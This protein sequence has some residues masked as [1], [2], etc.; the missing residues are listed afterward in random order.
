LIHYFPFSGNSSDEVTGQAY[1]SH[2]ATY[3]SD[4]KG[5]EASAI[6]FNGING[7]MELGADLQIPEGTLALWIFP[8][9]CKEYNPLFVKKSVETDGQFGQYYV[10]YS[11]AGRIETSCNGKWNLETGVAIEANKWFH[12]AFRWN[13]ATG[14]IDVFVNGKKVLSEQYSTDPSKFPGGAGETFLGKILNKSASGEEVET[15]YY[16]GKLDEIRLY[17][18]ALPYDAIKELYTE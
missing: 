11:E 9:L 3:L 2:G 17:D 4:R 1:D 16:K 8:C 12:L 10:G 14:V 6:F 18:K 7:W 5:A 13:D 15:V